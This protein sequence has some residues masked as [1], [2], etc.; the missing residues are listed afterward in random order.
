MTT[1]A[2]ASTPEVQ[3][4][5]G[6]AAATALAAAGAPVDD[7]FLRATAA[8]A[9]FTARAECPVRDVERRLATVLARCD[10]TIEAAEQQHNSSAAHDAAQRDYCAGCYWPIVATIMNE[11][12]LSDTY[13]CAARHLASR[14]HAGASNASALSATEAAPLAA[15]YDPR[16]APRFTACLANVQGAAA[17]HAGGAGGGARDPLGA[18]AARAAAPRCW[19]ADVAL[20]DAA[21]KPLLAPLLQKRLEQLSCPGQAKG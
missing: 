4:A 3:A 15:L 10:A 21:G 14:E 1:A 9:G 8:C 18:P 11:G 6:E 2:A 12:E 20:R 13:W 7:A 19:R 16:V 5:C 17:K